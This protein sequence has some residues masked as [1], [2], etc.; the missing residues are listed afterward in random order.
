MLKKKWPED[1]QLNGITVIL[2]DGEWLT[3]PY[4]ADVIFL[5]KLKSLKLVFSNESIPSIEGK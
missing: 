4:I 5:I 3:A 1:V 2:Q